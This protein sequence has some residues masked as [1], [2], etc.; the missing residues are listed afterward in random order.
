MRDATD[1]A[2]S[3]RAALRLALLDYSRSP[4]KYQVALRQPQFLFAALR[5]V[6][7][8]AVGRDGENGAG[9]NQESISLRDSA[10][11]F[12][13]T[14]L[15]YPGADHYALLGLDRRTENPELKDRYRLMMRLLH[16]D[17]SGPGAGNWP[18]DA[19]VRVNRA[20]DTLSSAVQRRLYDESLVQVHSA[21]VQGV[22]I[23]RPRPIPPPI[24]DDAR[25][26]RFKKLAVA[27]ALAG[28][29][30]GIVG[31]FA[32]SSSDTVQLVQRTRA[33]S[34][35]V[36]L[37]TPEREQPRPV[38]HQ[39]A[40]KP[41][42]TPVQLQPVPATPAANLA[43]SQT[44]VAAPPAPA[45][46]RVEVAR[47]T[48]MPQA[49]GHPSAA[50]PSPAPAAE[51]IPQRVMEIV[52]EARAA[53]TPPPPAPEPKL[54]VATVTVPVITPPPSPAAPVLVSAPPL[55]A[56]PPPRPALKPG[57]TLMEAQPL[58]SQLLQVMESGRGERI[59]NLLDAE[60]RNKPSAQAL[61][62]QYDS[63]VDGARPVRVSHV[64]FKAQP[65][66]GRL[67]V[68]GYFRVMAGE[69]TI[70]SIGKKMVL[71]AEFVSR[72]GNVVIT[73]LSG[74]VVN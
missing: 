27:G 14:A 36:V 2:D 15:L 19:A 62:R 8:I 39:P 74:G 13:R 17:F 4:G 64:E 45:Q 48:A 11:F 6:L 28:A 52:R 41:Q 12:V 33:Q 49:V 73:G 68:V 20:Y 54:Q 47:A 16:P 57:P 70:G 44:A 61:S 7:Q 60:A 46:K 38:T 5:E 67:L 1:S 30:L 58:L 56:A 34:E 25:Q 31:L 22:D 69:Q 40:I 18:A 24:E 66:D 23:R 9:V 65:G 35:A 37:A 50:L 63:L 59:L 53:A 43:Q 72:E 55:P 71:R 10:R 32:T 3:S 29:G 42:E 21:G 26:S 51:P